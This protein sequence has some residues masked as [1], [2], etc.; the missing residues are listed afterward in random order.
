MRLSDKREWQK[1][2]KELADS[3]YEVA[4]EL[5]FE[6]QKSYING[7]ALVEHIFEVVEYLRDDLLSQFS[8][9]VM[10]GT[11]TKAS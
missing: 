6:S 7:E 10:R 3:L 8:T 9:Q 1:V 5:T 2:A 4:D 11:E